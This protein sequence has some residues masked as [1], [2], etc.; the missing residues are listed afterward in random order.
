M[1][2]KWEDPFK[3]N[4]PTSPRGGYEGQRPSCYCSSNHGLFIAS[5]QLS[6]IIAGLL[7][8]TFFIFMTGY[9]LGKKSIVEQFSEQIQQ[10]AFADQVYT[11]VLANAQENDPTSPSYEGQRQSITTQTLTAEAENNENISSSIN[12]EI[13]VA[14]ATENESSKIASTERYYAQLIGF[15]TEKAA[16][17]F[18]K[19]LATKG[20][21]TEI[22]K[23]HV[24]LPPALS[25]AMNTLLKSP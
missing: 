25:P 18:V 5:R 7:F 12:Q 4:D 20:I 1:I 6:F 2:N 9:F 24:T 8:L 21:E 11:S 3:K 17:Q 16:Q 22:K 15:G 14:Q 19:K 23:N 13:V 10:E